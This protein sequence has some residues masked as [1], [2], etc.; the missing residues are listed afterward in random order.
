MRKILFPAA[1]AAV[2]ALSSCE[3]KGPVIDFG[4]GPVAVDT[5]YEITNIP[6]AQQRKVLVEEFTGG[7]CANCPAA[8]TLLQGI[9]DNSNDRVIPMEI[10]IFN[11]QQSNPATKEGAKYD[12]R[13][14]DGTDISVQYYGTIN[15]M[16]SA[17]INRVGATDPERLLL[18][19]KWANAITQELAKPSPVNLEV[20]SAV[21]DGKATIK[22]KTTYV[23]AVDKKQLLSLAILEDDIVDVQEFP[24]SFDH[25]YTFHHT[26]RDFL[27][28]VAGQA[29]LADLATKKAGTVYERTFIYDVPAAWKPENCKVVAFIHNEI[30]REVVQAASTKLKP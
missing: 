25:N 18:A 12:F 8:R 9:V 17:G 24:D 20:T 14:Q 10:H 27:T 13:T 1:I 2:F 7:M 26:L 6:A 23:Q 29:F 21:A 15:Q 19:G 5:T 16:P 22:V 3:E 4:G 11:F 30:D 28:P